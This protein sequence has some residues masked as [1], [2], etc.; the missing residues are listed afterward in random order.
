MDSNFQPWKWPIGMEVQVDAYRDRS[1]CSETVDQEQ[2]APKPK[3][4]MLVQNTK[5]EIA[6]RAPNAGATVCT[7]SG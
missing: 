4:A 2:L 1:S 6:A 3:T 5:L 7:C